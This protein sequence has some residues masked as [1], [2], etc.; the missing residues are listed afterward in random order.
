MYLVL[1][2]YALARGARGGIPLH[3]LLLAQPVPP[4][5]VRITID[6]PSSIDHPPS[7]A[8]AASAAAALAA[9]AG[10]GTAT[11]SSLMATSGGMLS[12]TGGLMGHE[13]EEELDVTPDDVP[14][15]TAAL[16]ARV[17]GLLGCQGAG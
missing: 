7:A 10:S 4:P 6:P 14:L 15:S 8:A 3:E 5:A 9:A 16:R 1:Q 12:A 11:T 17:S 13:G 2:A